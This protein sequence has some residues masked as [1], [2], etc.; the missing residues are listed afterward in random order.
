MSARANSQKAVGRIVFALPICLAILYI[1][2]LSSDA[3][4]QPPPLAVRA[5]LQLITLIAFLAVVFASQRKIIRYFEMRG[6]ALCND[7]QVCPMC[8]HSVAQVRGP[9]ACSECGTSYTNY[10]L[11]R[12]WEAVFKS[13]LY[14]YDR[15]I[16]PLKDRPEPSD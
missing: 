12:Y 13:G 10:G 7:G 3:F 8:G 15:I 9:G 2:H 5:A 16:L 14:D 4:I 1:I 11:A 6:G